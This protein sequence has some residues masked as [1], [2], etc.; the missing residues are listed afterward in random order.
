MVCAG[1]AKRC[2]IELSK[3][4]SSSRPWSGSL[5]MSQGV[6]RST[7]SPALGFIAFKAFR[8]S[9]S[10]RTGSGSAFR[11]ASRATFRTLP[12]ASEG[13][14]I[15]VAHLRCHLLALQSTM[16]FW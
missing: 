5:S 2:S 1:H 10:S 8:R 11:T 7:P 13:S 9:G 6:R 15:G 16:S 14:E 4:A 12:R 3:D